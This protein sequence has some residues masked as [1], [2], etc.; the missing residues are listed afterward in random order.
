MSTK[1]AKSFEGTV[2]VPELKLFRGLPA[3]EIVVD[4]SP[5]EEPKSAFRKVQ[6]KET[7]QRRMEMRKLMDANG[8]I[9]QSLMNP[10]ILY[11]SPFYAI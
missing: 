5:E 4:T 9:L 7:L 2:T 11:E 10:K 1:P 3:A 6:S 8:E